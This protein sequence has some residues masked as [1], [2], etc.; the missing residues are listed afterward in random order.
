MQTYLP[1]IRNTEQGPKPCIPFRLFLSVSI[2]FLTIPNITIKSFPTKTKELS[3]SYLLEK[4]D[5]I[6]AQKANFK[7]DSKMNTVYSS[8]I[9]LICKEIKSNQNSLT[10][11]QPYHT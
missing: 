6:T 2:V 8:I 10:S 5:T 9:N 7:Q 11:L 3:L 4:P 1:T